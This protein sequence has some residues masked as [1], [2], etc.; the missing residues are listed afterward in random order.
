[1]GNEEGIWVGSE[2]G[3]LM[4]KAFAMSARPGATKTTKVPATPIAINAVIIAVVIFSY[5]FAIR[6]NLPCIL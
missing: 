2:E 6:Y 1:M 3:I 4:G 5:L